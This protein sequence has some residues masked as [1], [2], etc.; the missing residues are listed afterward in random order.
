MSTRLCMKD[1]VVLTLE[2]EAGV[3]VRVSKIDAPEL[4]PVFLRKECTI[5]KVNEWIKRRLIPDDRE[6][7]DRVKKTFKSWDKV[8]PNCMPSLSDSYWLCRAGATWEKINCYK[9][10]S[11]RVG[12]MFFTPYSAKLSGKG[13]SPDLST[14][15]RLMKRWKKGDDGR[16]RLYKAG[17]RRLNIEPLSEVIVSTI[18]ERTKILPFVRYD[19]AVEGVYMCSVCE[20]FI[21]PGQALVTADEIFLQKE[22]G[23]NDT[24]FGHLVKMCEMLDIPN[25]EDYL[26]KLIYLDTVTGNTDRQLRDI[27]FILDC[28]KNKFIGPAP[29]FDNGSAYTDKEAFS[30]KKSKLFASE[31]DEAKRKFKGKFDFSFLGDK[32]YYKFV[33]SYPRVN[34]RAKGFIINSLEK[35]D[36]EIEE[37][38]L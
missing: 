29:L 15:G 7:L 3:P 2:D 25:S 28:E 35:S 30:G 11:E 17:S 36:R 31:Q 8:M 38:C 34:D 24:I 21:K 32:A 37:L 18:L 22:K 6:G 12:D 14:N 33:K 23:E 27:G 13:Q 9:A 4:L 19:L 26:W 1:K 5:E 16:I 20:N 10:F